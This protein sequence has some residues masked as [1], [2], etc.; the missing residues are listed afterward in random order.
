MLPPRPLSDVNI[1]ILVHVNRELMP[2]SQR[3][4]CRAL[5]YCIAKCKIYIVF[6][7]QRL[8]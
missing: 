6:D 8:I 5:G 4:N 2:I 1:A 3:P 7:S